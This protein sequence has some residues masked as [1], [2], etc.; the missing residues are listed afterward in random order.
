MKQIFQSY[1]FVFSA[2]R[3]PYRYIG[4]LVE[5]KEK[6]ETVTDKRIPISVKAAD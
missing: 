2:D 6:R 5:K 1:S 3:L 4:L